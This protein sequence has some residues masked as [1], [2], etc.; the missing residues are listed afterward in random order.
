MAWLYCFIG[1]GSCPAEL[2]AVGSAA[3]ALDPHSRST[4]CVDEVLRRL[5]GA[6]P[7]M[8]WLYCFIGPGSCPAELFAVGSA[9]SALDRHSRST[10]CVDESLRRLHGAQP[11][12]A[13]LYCFIGPGSC[14]AEIFAVGSAAGTSS[15]GTVDP[16]HAWMNFCAGRRERSH[17]CRGFT[18]SSGRRAHAVS[19]MLGRNPPSSRCRQSAPHSNAG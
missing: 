2:F 18:V 14:P 1:P 17:A 19:T 4:P 8:A 15:T 7:R 5:H 6:Q 12:M 13:W 9:A 10:P 11:R 3:S 16:R